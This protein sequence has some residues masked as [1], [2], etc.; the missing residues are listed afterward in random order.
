M[1]NCP[2][3]NNPCPNPKD[4]QVIKTENGLEINCEACQVCGPS[5]FLLHKLKCQLQSELNIFKIQDASELR[6]YVCKSCG[7]SLTEITS[8]P[9]IGCANCYDAH[10][11]IVSQMLDRCQKSLKHIGKKPKN[12]EINYISKN[13]KE[14]IEILEQKIIKAVK[15]ENYEIA[16]MLK[17]KIEELKKGA[18]DA[19]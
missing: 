11:L 2:F 3:T 17:K 10:R 15:V 4:M 6:K 18:S 16:A 7:M 9:F 5:Y 19:K 12:L 1:E 14:Q 13:V 8:Q